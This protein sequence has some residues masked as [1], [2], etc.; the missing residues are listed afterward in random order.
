M[1]QTCLLLHWYAA[2]G[3]AG[4]TRDRHG[5]ER[6]EEIAPI[7]LALVSVSLFGE[8]RDNRVR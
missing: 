3:L 7:V 4:C 1:R 8:Q 2:D 5:T 6:A